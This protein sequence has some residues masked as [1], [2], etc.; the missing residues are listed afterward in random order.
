V[1]R[2]R[3]IPQGCMTVGQVAKRMNTTVRTLQYYDREG[4]LSPCAESEGGRRLYTDREIVK[5]HQIQSMKYLGF[6]LDDIKNRLVSLDTPEDMAAALAEQA[7][8]IRAKMASL[9]EVL[10]A[11]E[12][13]REE[14]LQMETVN[15]EKYADIVVNLQM[16]NEFYGMIKYFDNDTLDRLRSRFNREKGEAVV[17]TMKRLLDRL[18]VLQEKEIP[19]ESQ[20][21]QVWAKDWWEM[22]LEFMGGDM[23]MLPNLVKMA[24]N[25]PAGDQ[26][27]VD[28]WAVAGPYIEK[29][30]ECYF[31]SRGLDPMKGAP[32]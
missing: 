11:L 30:M 26:K 8:A 14:T 28:R 6:S 25:P 9:A 12:A 10:A 7:Q 13:L 16:K 1:E 4:L 21:G 31:A 27:W 32:V 2:H 15:F 18:A 24:E 17:K 3:A 29:A 22:V 23:G 5:L 19:P 20:A